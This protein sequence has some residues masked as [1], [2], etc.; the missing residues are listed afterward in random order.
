MDVISSDV[1]NAS[2]KFVGQRVV[3]GGVQ[4]VKVMNVEVVAA[5]CRKDATR[6][7]KVDMCLSSERYV[8]MNVYLLK[9]IIRFRVKR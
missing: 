7:V 1:S 3:P 6:S 9:H 8:F 5:R 2:S 4:A